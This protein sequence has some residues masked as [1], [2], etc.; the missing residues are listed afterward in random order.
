VV[1]ACNRKHNLL[2]SRPEFME[3][4]IRGWITTKA[5]SL[6]SQNY[7]WSVNKSLW[8]LSFFAGPRPETKEKSAPF[9]TLLK[10][11][12]FPLFGG[13]LLGAV[14]YINILS[15]CV[16]K[17]IKMKLLHNLFFPPRVAIAVCRVSLGKL[18]Y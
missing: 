17:N 9:E 8:L 13:L 3:I 4:I 5:Q 15:S 1:P 12:L 14:I 6:L 2:S 16:D 10:V 11:F 7:K 18:F